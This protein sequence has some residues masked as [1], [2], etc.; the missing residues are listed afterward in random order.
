MIRVSL[1]AAALALSAHGVTAGGIDRS[2]QPIGIIF[3]TGNYVEFSF[4]SANPEVSGVG[5]PTGPTP[6]ATTGDATPSY[7]LFSSGLKFA[8]N[9]QVDAALIFDQPFGADLAYP[10]SFYFASGATANLRSN[11]MTGIVRY[12]FAD[13]FSVYAGLRQQT[14][15]ANVGVPYVAGYTANGSNDTQLGYLIGAAY[16]RP[17]IALRVALTYYSS[18]DHRLSTFETSG[19]APLGVTSTTKIETPQAINLDFQTGIAPKTLLFGGVRWVEWSKFA[20]APSHFA[21]ITGGAPL[22]S[23]SDDRLTYSL[24]IGRQLSDNWSVAASVTHEPQV[25][26]FASNLSPTD[27]YSSVGVGAIYR[28]DNMKLQAGVSHTWIGDATTALFGAPAGNFAD[29]TAL[30]FGLKVGF[31]F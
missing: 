1:A 4:R 6:G 22:V 28:Q 13:K 16:E 25:G 17:D 21:A 26:G 3:E 29:N 14:M 24:G 27:G 23:F 30:G 31:N 18:V 5:A 15:K 8:I 10:P 19:F 12:K 20:I 7:G 2:G 9:D 11:A